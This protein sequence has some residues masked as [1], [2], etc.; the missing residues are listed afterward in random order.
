[1]KTIDPIL[2]SAT[3]LRNGLFITRLKYSQYSGAWSTFAY[4]ALY[5]YEFNET[6]L[7]AEIEYPDLN[8]NVPTKI[9][10]ERG[11]RI[12]ET[13]YYVDS[14]TFFLNNSSYNAFSRRCSITA[15]VLP[16]VPSTGVNGAQQVSNVL[17]ALLVPYLITAEY[18]NRYNEP[19]KAWNMFPAGTT[20]NMQSLQSLTSILAHKYMV[21]IIP[22][23][24]GPYFIN[25]G[26]ANLDTSIETPDKIIPLNDNLSTTKSHQSSSRYL[27]YIDETNTIHT[28]GSSKNPTHNLGYIEST[29]STTD[30]GKLDNASIQEQEWEITPDL[31]LENGD[32]I[33]PDYDE[34]DT[35]LIV[36]REAYNP[37]SE[38][39]F[40]QWIKKP[41]YLASTTARFTLADAPQDSRNHR[42]DTFNFNTI[43]S[44]ADETIQHAFETIDDHIHTGAIPESGWIERSETWTRTGNYTFTISGDVT[45][46]YRKGTKIRYKD[47]GAFEYGVV[48]SSSYSA[49][50][51]T[52]TLA[53]N[54]DYAMASNPTDR[55]ISFVENPEG[56][57]TSFSIATTT[58]ITSSAGSLS[59]IVVAVAKIAIIGGEIKFW[60]D[61]TFDLGSATALSIF[62]SLPVTPAFTTAFV[63]GC[64]DA[65]SGAV[66]VGLGAAVAANGTIWRLLSGSKWSVGN[67]KRF[68]GSG[69]V[70]F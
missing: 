54:S 68:Y 64:R 40:R 3:S 45:A 21:S 22:G 56:F 27:L 8:T 63:A 13:N 10:I 66:P 1:M 57:P 65:S 49:P 4:K 53:A 30:I 35:K 23:R 70:L 36:I 67:T 15:H 17:Y 52:V 16:N 38:P 2:A 37:S 47:G 42:L 60:F 51:T 29:V 24:S 58:S 50:N 69:S 62:A 12:G 33:A 7:K 18:P 5:K 32:I 14:P 41:E 6:S 31:A 26:L 25:F 55:A 61:V 9:V 19:W 20:L 28:L 11:F 44:D 59:N 43:L 34:N 48:I 39:S 46:T